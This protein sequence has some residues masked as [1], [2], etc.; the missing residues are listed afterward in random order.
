MS[1]IFDM[2]FLPGWIGPLY[3][4]TVQVCET[5]ELRWV[6]TPPE[7]K[8]AYDVPFPAPMLTLIPAPA[9]NKNRQ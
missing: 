2:V 7:G 9:S 6:D 1:R 4:P 8:T 3:F 5:G